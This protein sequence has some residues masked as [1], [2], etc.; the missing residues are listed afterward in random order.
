[1]NEY[2]KHTYTHTHTHTHKFHFLVTSKYLSFIIKRKRNVL[3]TRKRT[4]CSMSSLRWAHATLS[5]GRSA[6]HRQIWMVALQ[7]LRLTLQLLRVAVTWFYCTSGTVGRLAGTLI[8]VSGKTDFRNAF[9]RNSPLAIYWFYCDVTWCCREGLCSW[10]RVEADVGRFIARAVGCRLLIT[11]AMI[12][13]HG[14]PGG[15]CFGQ[16]GPGQDSV[17]AV[18]SSHYSKTPLIRINWD[19]DPS[20]YAEHPDNWIFLWK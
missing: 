10:L 12:Q 13:P 5:N 14:S 20:G 2:D 11:E 16:S 15:I 19:G 17:R 4:N 7:C 9:I 6:G 8:S 3:I 18:W 1:M